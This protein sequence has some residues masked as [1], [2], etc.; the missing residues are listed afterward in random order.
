VDIK[1]AI[2]IAAPAEKVWAVMTD[3]ERWPEWTPSVTDVERLDA[4]PFGIGSRARIRQPRLPAA[5]WTVT[6]AEMGRHFEWRNATPGLKT[7]ASH[8]IEPQAANDCRVTLTLG[9][10]GLLAPLVRL[11]LGRLSSRY[12]EME[13]EGLK[14]R[15]EML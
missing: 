1:R 14:R 5:V 3:V 10:M 4:G 12:V 2:E 11:A 15:C 9:W 8:R 13:A 6:D 7:V